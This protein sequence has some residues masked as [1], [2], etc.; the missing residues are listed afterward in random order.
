[1]SAE[2]TEKFPFAVGLVGFP[3]QAAAAIAQGLKRAPGK[4]PAYFCLSAHSLQEP[5][6]YLANGTHLSTLAALEGLTQGG[7]RPALVLGAPGIELAHPDFPYPNL[8]LPVQW[9]SVFHE[10]GKLVERRAEALAERAASGQPAPTERRRSPRVDLDL[11]DPAEYLAMRQPA[12]HGEVLV[13]DRSDAL[14]V[15][16]AKLMR[17][18]D[19]AASWAGGADE[20][21]AACRQRAVA[22]MLVNT[23]VVDAYAMAEAVPDSTVVVPMVADAAEYDA[24]R[25]AAAGIAGFV[26]KPVSDATLRSVLKRLLRLS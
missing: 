4:G 7:T 24:E 6:L 21:I 25:A 14:A 12:P 1:M 17:R 11:T 8:R 19:V 5:D 20:A 3:P 2:Q 26:D 16:I 15:H 10:L 23:A 18:Q 22:V 9:D 13:V